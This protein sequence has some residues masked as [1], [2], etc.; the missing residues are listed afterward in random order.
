MGLSEIKN[1]K[2]NNWK[3]LIELADQRMYFAKKSGR[4]R[5]IG[6]DDQI[7]GLI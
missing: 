5:C 2:S 4:A 1:D 3:D 6:S 7:L